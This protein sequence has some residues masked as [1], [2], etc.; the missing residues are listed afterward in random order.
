MRKKPLKS[1]LY[2]EDDLHVRTTAKLV[3]EVIG[4]IDVRECGSGREALLTARDFT[5]DLILLDVMMPEIDGVGTLALLRRLPHLADVP[6]LFVTGLTEPDDI[7][8]YMEAGA[9]GVIPKPVMPMRLSSQLHTLWDER[10][11]LTA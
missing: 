6:A 4:K 9:I 1:I 7:A 5:P 3:L 10:P 8:R 2:V 11:G